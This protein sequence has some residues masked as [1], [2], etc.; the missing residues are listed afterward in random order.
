[1]LERAQPAIARG[2]RRPGRARRARA[3]HASALA[4]LRVRRSSACSTP[5]RSRCRRIR[6]QAPAPIAPPSRLRGMIADAGVTLVVSSPAVRAAGRRARGC[7]FRSSPDLPWLDLDDVDDDAGRRRGGAPRCNERLA[8]VPAI[9]VRLHRPHRAAS[10]VTHGNLLAQPRATRADWR[11]Y[12]RDSVVGLVAAGQPRHGID[13]RRP[14][15]GVQRLPALP[16]VAGGVP[17]APGAVAAG[18]LALRRDAQRRARTSPTTCAPAA[19]ATRTAR[20]L[21][22]EHVARGLQRVRTGPALDARGLSRAFAALRLRWEL[23]SGVRARG[24]DTAGQPAARPERHLS[25]S[26]TPSGRT[27]V[28]SA[29]S[30][31]QPRIGSSTLS[32]A[33]RG[34]RRR[35]GEIWVAGASVA[36]G[37]WNKPRRERRDVPARSSL[38]A[39]EGPYLRTGDLGSSSTD[40]CSSPAGS[41]TC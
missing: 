41:R 27:L 2:D 30:T 6:R 4:R 1:M 28:S 26:R 35:V 15:A 25:S 16:D 24:I 39:C 40:S 17:A 21:D 3:G 31:A 22:L 32:R 36:G 29:A 38:D 23:Q 12:D 34:R 8:G 5:A 33:S 19:S 13:Q 10:M 20:A 37:Y 18:D 14:A 11:S 7:S 9:H